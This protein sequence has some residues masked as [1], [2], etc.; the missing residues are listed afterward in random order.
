MPVVRIEPEGSEVPARPGETILEALY[1]S[2]FSYRIGCR[3]GGCAI[4]KVDLVQGSVEYNRPVAEEVLPEAE[5][6]TGTCLTCRA[7]PTEDVVIRLRDEALRL[8]NRMLRRIRLTQ[9][10]KETGVA[11]EASSTTPV[12]A[13]PTLLMHSATTTPSASPPSTERDEVASGISKEP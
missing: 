8:T 2:G 4:C 5:R 12:S 1:A 3:R 10:A 7:V 9:Y 6:A 13:P 11:L